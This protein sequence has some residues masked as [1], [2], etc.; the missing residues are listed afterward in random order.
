[1]K[2]LNKSGKKPANS[3]VTYASCT[4]CLCTCNCSITLKNDATM[5]NTP[6]N[7]GMAAGKLTDTK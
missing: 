4:I 2:K 6:K 3:L 1:M 5:Y 7:S